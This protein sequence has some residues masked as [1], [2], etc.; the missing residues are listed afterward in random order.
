V[1]QRLRVLEDLGEELERAIVAGAGRPARSR[2]SVRSSVVTISVAVASVAVVVLV[3]VVALGTRP[4]AGTRKPS[5]PLRHSAPGPVG[6]GYQVGAI[7]RQ[8]LLDNFAVL[9]RPQTAE[10]RTWSPQCSCAGSAIQENGLTRLAQTLPGG[11]RIFF[12][13]EQFTV[14]GQEGLR[15]G[16]YV[17]NLDRTETRA[18]VSLA[19]TCSTW[20]TRSRL[21]AALG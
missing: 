17:L 9:R 8:E 7:T 15:A 14:G 2:R 19:R 5:A 13:V 4:R 3:G 1:S 18:A 10:D 16:S 21:V 12:D 20:S 6:H 11:Y